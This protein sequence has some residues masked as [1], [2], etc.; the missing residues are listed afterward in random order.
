M[1]EKILVARADELKQQ[2]DFKRFRALPEEEI[3]RLYASVELVAMERDLVENDPTYRQVVC[4]T[5]IHYNYSWFTFV[6]H[7]THDGAQLQKKRSMCLGGHIHGDNQTLFLDERL[8]DPALREVNEGLLIPDRIDLRLA[9]LLNDDSDDVSRFHLGLVYVA[10]LSQA[11]IN[12]R[13]QGIT[14]IRFCGVGD[15]L[16][17]RDHFET[18]SQ[19][20][21]DH[22][23]A[24]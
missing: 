23:Q 20:L 12:K 21:I 17:D 3:D 24:L 11:G 6:R 22:L 7:S 16:Q 18:T 14:D 1:G 8:K 4:C 13:D 10:K 9:G 19:I 5:V 2:V 15:L